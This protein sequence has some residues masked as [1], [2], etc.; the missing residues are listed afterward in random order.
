M[1]VREEQPAELLTRGGQANLL[2]GQV[3]EQAAKFPRGEIAVPAAENASSAEL[4]FVVEIQQRIA[5]HL[6]DVGSGQRQLRRGLCCG[7][8]GAERRLAVA[9]PS[10]RGLG[11]LLG[12]L[13]PLSIY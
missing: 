10:L 11:L 5:D 2:A 4:E 12:R 3:V 9:R 6:E 8:R 7:D 13:A 1:L